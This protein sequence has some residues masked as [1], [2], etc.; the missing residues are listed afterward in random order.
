MNVL[1]VCTGNF[2]Y[3]KPFVSEQ[4]YAL[5]KLGVHTDYYLIKGKGILGYLKNLYPLRKKIKHG[6]YD[7]LHAHFG[8]SGF[9]SILQCKLPVVISFLTGEQLFWY[10]NILSSISILFSKKNIFVSESTYNDIFIKRPTKKIVIPL[11]VQLDIFKPIDRAFAKK[12]MNISESKINI[13]FASD[14]T[15]E[16]FYK[17][18]KLAF[19][20]VSKMENVNLIELRNYNRSQVNFLLNAVDLLLLTSKVEGSPMIIREAMACNCPIVATDVG[21]IKEVIHETEGCFITSF[22]SEDVIEKIQMA[23]KFGKRTNG[24][25]KIIRK[26]DNLIL[27]KRIIQVYNEVRKNR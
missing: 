17:N 22:N 21:D 6:K 13:L 10:T 19:N 7:L 24:R 11:G 20:A 5:N 12:K 25:E 4:V 8:L 27:A 1:I 14:F 18:P 16:K 3:I 23:I 2:G 15:K 26:Y 9:L